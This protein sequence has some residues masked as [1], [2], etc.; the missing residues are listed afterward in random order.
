MKFVSWQEKERKKSI[1]RRL[2]WWNSVWIWDVSNPYSDSVIG[3]FFNVCRSLYAEADNSAGGSCGE[4]GD[5]W[6][7]CSFAKLESPNAVCLLSKFQRGIMKSPGE[8]FNKYATQ[9]EKKPTWHSKKIFLYFK[10]LFG[11]FLRLLLAA[12][13]WPVG[14][15]YED[16]HIASWNHAFEH[17]SISPIDDTTKTYT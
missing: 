6:M 8:F 17:V 4:C 1:W 11:P 3:P 16:L 9:A 7:L 15:V 13:T 5:F 2:T 10:S 12:L 14:Q